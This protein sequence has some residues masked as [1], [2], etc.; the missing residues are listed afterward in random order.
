[1][2]DGV[3]APVDVGVVRSVYVVHRVEHRERLLRR[4]RRVEVHEPLALDLAPEDREVALDRGDVELR[5]VLRLSALAHAALFRNASKP[6]D[7]TWRA[8]S[9]PPSATMRPSTSTCTASG[10][11][12]WSS[13]W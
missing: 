1:L 13:R 9:G 12:C 10:T 3:H 4:R 11:R 5:H 8:S 2:G 7:S 6:W